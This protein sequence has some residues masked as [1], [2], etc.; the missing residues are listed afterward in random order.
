MG[1]PDLVEIED[2][3]RRFLTQWVE[4]PDDLDDI[5]QL[6][7]VKVWRKWS[8]FERKSRW[9]SWVYRLTRNEFITW[10]RKEESWQRCSEAA[11]RPQASEDLS[12]AVVGE[13]WVR[14]LLSGLN[15]RQ[16][17]LMELLVLH[18]HTSVEVGRC[19]GA[20]PSTIRCWKREARRE[21]RDSIL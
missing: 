4:D 13:V 16:R 3:I 18:G 2:V 8:T 15:R 6:C 11:I 17:E 21:L 10:T 5:S 12:E 1:L 20:A 9:T 19:L 7:L 14:R